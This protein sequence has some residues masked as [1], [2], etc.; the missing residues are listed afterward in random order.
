MEEI[1][2]DIELNQDEN[3]EGKR[4]LAAG[5]CVLWVLMIL[6]SVFLASRSL[7]M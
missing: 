5:K 4:L 7:M 6:V 1:R 2:M 3:R